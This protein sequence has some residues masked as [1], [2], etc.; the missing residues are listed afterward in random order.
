MSTAL[1]IDDDPSNSEAIAH[2]L[3]YNDYNVL[4]TVDALQA[5]RY[6]RDSKIDIIVADVLLRSSCSGTEIVSILHK[7]CAGIPVLF[8]SGTSLEG[9]SGSDFANL[10][11]LLPGRV[12][13]LMKPFTAKAL[14]EAVS[15]LLHPA[16]SEVEIRSKLDMAKKFRYAA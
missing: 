1:V 6:C 5:A 3:E 10:E 11:A 16:Y 8:V 15:K 9:W 2:V 7:S 12:E 4:T 13:F 14:V